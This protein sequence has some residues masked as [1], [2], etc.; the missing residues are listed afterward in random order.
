[1]E[2]ATPLCDAFLFYAGVLGPSLTSL[3]LRVREGQH[4]ISSYCTFPDMGF[5][6]PKLRQLTMIGYV[7]DIDS[8]AL[9]RMPCLTYLM[10][11]GSKWKASAS[12]RWMYHLPTSVDVLGVSP[13]LLDLATCGRFG[14]STALPGVIALIRRR[15]LCVGRVSSLRLSS[16]QQPF[17]IQLTNL[18]LVVLAG[19]RLQAIPACIT[20]MSTLK[21]LD[22]SRN[23]LTGLPVGP[24]LSCLRRLWAPWCKI[25]VFPLEAISKATALRELD[26]R[27]KGFEW[28]EEALATTKNMIVRDAQKQ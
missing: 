9:E 18:V 6:M 5:S 27:G 17:W 24:Y 1:M 20:S 26:L 28:T 25:S 3:F 12:H 16:S 4:Q 14:Q 19:C 8:N 22:V 21:G 23:H 11:G 7:D 2:Q 13:S 10:V 15:A